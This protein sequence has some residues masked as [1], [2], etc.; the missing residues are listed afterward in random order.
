MKFVSMLAVLFAS[1]APAFAS[2]PGG[3]DMCGL[4]WQVT[5]KKSFLA[6]TTR[7]TTNYVV[8]STFGM[9]SGTIGCDQHSIAQR[10]LPAVNYVATNKD[11][12]L[13]EMAAGKGESLSALAQ[14][15]GCSDA[16][17]FARKAQESYASLAS[18]SS[19]EL[20][21]NVKAFAVAQGCAI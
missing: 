2:S 9:T 4:G 19:V 12:L 6:T 18:S 14:T 13:I 3:S 15:M 5:D 11:A 10:E 20:Y 17:V 8:P 21:K 7:G 16:Q 1:V